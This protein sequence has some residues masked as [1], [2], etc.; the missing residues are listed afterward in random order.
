MKKPNKIPTIANAPIQFKAYHKGEDRFLK[1][2]ELVS[3]GMSTYFKKN[4]VLKANDPQLELLMNTL[5]QDDDRNAIFEMDVVTM[6]VATPFG[7]MKKKALA[8]FDRKKSK[9]EFKFVS[10]MIEDG[11]SFKVQGCKRQ[12]N[13]LDNNDLLSD[14]QKQKMDLPA[15]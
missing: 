5:H 14:D 6:D 4:G 2:D 15:L 13:L 7:V 11:L 10:E 9:F 12:G 3:F 8:Q 1:P